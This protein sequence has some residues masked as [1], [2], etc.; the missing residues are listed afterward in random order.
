MCVAPAGSRG[1][2]RCTQAMHVRVFVCVPVLVIVAPVSVLASLTRHRRPPPWHAHTRI[3]TGTPPLLPPEQKELERIPELEAQLVVLAETRG[4]LAQ[5]QAKL[6]ATAG[7]MKHLEKVHERD[8]KARTSANMKMKN[9]VVRHD[10]LRSR[11]T[12]Q[13]SNSVGHGGTCCA[14]CCEDGG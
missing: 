8:V 10:T 12:P 7:Q 14:R 13:S 1:A 2:V 3:T 9:A 11:H 5:V 4:E 6:D